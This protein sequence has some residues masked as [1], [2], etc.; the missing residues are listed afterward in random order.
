[1][2]LFARVFCFNDMSYKHIRKDYQKSVFDFDSA[3]SNPVDQ[4]R[5]WLNDAIESGI[6]DANAMC[7]STVDK[8]GH[9]HSR[10]VLLKEANQDGIVFFTNYRSAKS[11]DIEFNPHVALNFYW[12]ELERQVRIEGTAKKLSRDLCVDYFDSRPI[13]SRISAIISLQSEIIPSK[14]ILEEQ[15]EYYKNNPD[16][17]HCPEHWGGFI[18]QPLSFEF[19]QGRGDR[20]HDRLK[21]FSKDSNHW[22]REILAP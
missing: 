4:F 12:C 21:Y 15:I 7:L 20:L 3:Q 19:W 5:L 8:I 1:M 13:N 2:N 18:V 11:I 16:Q 22:I 17:I 6:P 9:P 10:M 14:Q